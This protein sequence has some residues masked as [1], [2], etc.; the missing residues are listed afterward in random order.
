MSS[1]FHH[2]RHLCSITAFPFLDR[3]ERAHDPLHSHGWVGMVILSFT[4]STA[5]RQLKEKLLLRVLRNAHYETGKL[6][7]D[8]GHENEE[9]RKIVQLIKAATICGEVYPL[10]PASKHRDRHCGVDRWENEGGAPHRPIN[11]LGD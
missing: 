8:K 3:G 1:Q 10:S 2:R 4:A 9:A 6:D 11:P 7:G 5:V